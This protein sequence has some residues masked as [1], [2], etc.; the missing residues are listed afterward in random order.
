MSCCEGLAPCRQHCACDFN[1]LRCRWAPASHA[2]L[3][4][5]AQG[6]PRSA[7]ERFCESEGIDLLIIGTRAGSKLKKTLT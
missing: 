1:K 7:L 2:A 6:D 3:R 5:A 4:C